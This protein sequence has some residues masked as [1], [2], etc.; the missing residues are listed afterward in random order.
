MK[1]SREMFIGFSVSNFLSFK[2]P[3]TMSMM[4]SKVARHKEHILNGNGKKIL[5][6]GLIYGANAGGKSNFIK[7]IDFSRDIILDGLEEVDLNR[8]YFRINKEGYRQPGVFEYRLITQSK[9]EY[10]YGIAIS[11]AAK[12]IISEWLVRIEKN[13]SETCIFNRDIDE[14]GEN[15]TFSE[16]TH[17]NEAEKIKWEIFLDV[18]GKNIS[19]AMKKKSILSDVAERSNEKS[20]VLKEIMDVYEWFQ[21]II[22]LFPTSQYSGLNQLVEKEEVRKFFSGILKYFDTGIESVESKQGEMNFDRI[23]EGI[24]KEHAEKLKIRIS[25]DIENDPVMFKVNN[26]VYSLRKDEEGNIITTKM[27]QNHGN[28]QE[29]F[30]YSDESDGTQRLFDLIP[31]FYEHQNNRVIFIDEID[32]SLHTNLT[33]RFL[34]LFYSLTEKSDC[35]IIATTHDSNLLDLDLVRQDEIWFIKRLEDHSSKMYS[36]NRYKERYD[37]KIDKEYLLGRYDAIPI[38]DEEILEDMND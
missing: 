28:P 11:Y 13:G 2:S 22:I 21:S 26:Q 25:N 32:R 19:P 9:K 36:L 8:K 15:F 7:A 18:F 33:R 10:S 31:L 29:L 12:E 3:Q 27:M 23:F 16:V 1:E 24:P 38:F 30:E 34:E 20:G 37:K 14:S 35:Q 4:A 6:T 5:K 17:K